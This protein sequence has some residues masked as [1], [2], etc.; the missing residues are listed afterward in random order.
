MI[1][2]LP[3]ISTIFRLKNDFLSFAWAKPWVETQP[4]DIYFSEP[5]WMEIRKRSP[6][7]DILDK[8]RA[9]MG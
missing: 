5:T 2:I 7:S 6:P 1:P 8:Y 4:N 3:T 9:I